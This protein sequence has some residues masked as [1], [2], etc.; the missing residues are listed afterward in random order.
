[1]T[2]L[3]YARLIG[4]PILKDT[5]GSRGKCVKAAEEVLDNTNRNVSTRKYYIDLGRKFK[6]PVRCFIFTGSMELAWHN[7]LYRA[8]NTPP[9][10]AARE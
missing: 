4:F 3:L 10:V 6:V 2:L 5:L 8:Y 1:S 9:S 7:N